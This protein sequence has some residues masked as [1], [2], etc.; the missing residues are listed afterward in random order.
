MCV[1]EICF[2]VNRYDVLIEGFIVAKAEEG[3]IDVLVSNDIKILCKFTGTVREVEDDCCHIMLFVKNDILGNDNK[4]LAG[5]ERNHGIYEKTIL[6]E[7]IK[8]LFC[9]VNMLDLDNRICSFTCYNS[10]ES[11]IVG[12]RWNWAVKEWIF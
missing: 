6:N 3:D 11:F 7:I 5:F 12:L 10:L 4:C 8:K 2:K 9:I 1:K